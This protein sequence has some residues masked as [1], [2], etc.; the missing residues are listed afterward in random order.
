VCQLAYT[1]SIDLCSGKMSGS[2]ALEKLPKVPRVGLPFIQQKMKM[3]GA[4]SKTEQYRRFHTVYFQFALL[5]LPRDVH[6]AS[7]LRHLKSLL[8]K[9]SG[10][11]LLKN[12]VWD[13]FEQAGLEQQEDVCMHWS[14]D[15]TGSSSGL[16]SAAETAALEGNVGKDVDGSGVRAEDTCDTGYFEKLC[17]TIRALM[18]TPLTRPF[19]PSE[20]EYPQKNPLKPSE[21]EEIRKGKHT[22]L[23]TIM[24]DLH[25]Y[26][27]RLSENSANSVWPDIGARIE[28]KAK[29]PDRQ[30]FL[31]V[32]DKNDRREWTQVLLK[33]RAALMYTID[34]GASQRNEHRW[35]LEESVVDE[36]RQRAHSSVYSEL[37]MTK[38]DE[39][40]LEYS[41]F[42]KL[43]FDLSSLILRNN[44]FGSSEISIV[45]RI[46]ETDVGKLLLKYDV[47]YT[48][49]VNR[50]LRAQALA[51]TPVP[52]CPPALDVP[53][54][55]EGSENTGGLDANHVEMVDAKEP[56][57]VL[58]VICEEASCTETVAVRRPKQKL[59][60]F[61][62][63]LQTIN[64]VVS[65]QNDK[66][67]L[68]VSHEEMCSDMHKLVDFIDFITHGCLP[69][70]IFEPP[71][72]D[73]SSVIVVDAIVDPFADFL[74]NKP[75]LPS[76]PCP[77]GQY[78]P[79]DGI[80][81]ALG[82]IRAKLD[83]TL[84]NP[85]MLVVPTARPYHR[86]RGQEKNT[87]SWRR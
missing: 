77:A 1:K 37:Q 17:Q 18:Q 19:S 58:K 66:S 68:A 54:S 81:T 45:Q 33:M 83:D 5:S 74:T 46:M 13:A 24:R 14:A 6:G 62:S 56:W 30:E 36:L 82:S 2:M 55:L 86:V 85:S 28:H 25:A 63:L 7:E 10:R 72:Q 4:Q 78:L 26:I 71:A 23:C 43:F 75:H 3:T 69:L 70:S 40:L 73:S 44:S 15:E 31:S 11:L 16:C 20:E 39:T 60:I 59:C 87:K 42:V 29:T 57:G 8:N 47:W 53:V 34:T 48:E 52:L 9:A 76:M 50:T 80:Q 27:K 21:E 12:D 41:K 38:Y 64:K 61:A 79:A 49:S 84:R 67:A 65:S 51:Q 32:Q 35:L 22:L